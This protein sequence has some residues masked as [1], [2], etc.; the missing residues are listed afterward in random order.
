MFTTRNYVTA[1]AT[2][3]PPTM[4]R[5]SET[6]DAVLPQKVKNVVERLKHGLDRGWISGNLRELIEN[7][8]EF[9]DVT[10]DDH[11]WSE[12]TGRSLSE[13]GISSEERARLRY[14]LR[15]VKEIWLR[16]QD[17]QSKGYDENAWCIDVIMPLVKLA[18]TLEGRGKFRLQ[19]VWVTLRL[20]DGT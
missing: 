16:A 20:V 2:A 19:S 8:P 5:Q 3:S 10:I 13:P 7:D 6:R 12:S 17:C 4:A 15:E 18:M 11:A 14:V 9:R 1:L